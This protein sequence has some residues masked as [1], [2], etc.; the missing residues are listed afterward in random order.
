MKDHLEILNYNYGL[1]W[2]T[3][4]RIQEGHMPN[5]VKRLHGSVGFTYDLLSGDLLK[6]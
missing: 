4:I 1:D 5:H 2:S 6:D 3:V